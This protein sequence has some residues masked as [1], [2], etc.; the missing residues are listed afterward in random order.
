MERSYFL[1]LR[2]IFRV[3]MESPP[4]DHDD[5]TFGDKVAIIPIIF[6]VVMIHSKFVDWSPS[7]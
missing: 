5:A 6:G 4:I 1:W 3:V 7:Q 2:V